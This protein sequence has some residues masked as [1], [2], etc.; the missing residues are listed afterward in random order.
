MKN[1][2]LPFF[3]SFDRLS[4]SKATA[5]RDLQDLVNKEILKKTGK[6]KSTRYELNLV[7]FYPTIS[8]ETTGK[9]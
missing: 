1:F 5:T 6:L 8:L 4:L 3:Y 7:P 9:R 2:I